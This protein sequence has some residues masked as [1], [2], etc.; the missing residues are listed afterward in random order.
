MNLSQHKRVAALGALTLLLLSTG[1]SATSQEPPSQK[2]KV[3]SLN[4]DTKTVNIKALMHYFN[5]SLN[6]LK[7]YMTSLEAFQNPQNKDSIRNELIQLEKKISDSQPQEIAETTGFDLSYNLMARHL[8]DTIR[9]YDSKIYVQAWE[10]MNATTTFCISCH[11]RLPEKVNLQILKD[12]TVQ[13]EQRP[14]QSLQDA[15]FYYLSHRYAHALE[16]YDEKIKNYPGNNLSPDE[17]KKIY[18]RKI[19]FYAR[20]HRNP[21]DAIESL[22]QDLKNKKLPKEYQ[23]HI[24][25]W[26]AGFNYLKKESTKNL[27]QLSDQKLL[28]YAQNIIS[29]SA[30]GTQISI[31]DPQAIP[32]LLSS[33]LLYERLFKNKNSDLVP[34]MLYALSQAE[35][36]LSTLR[37][38]SLSDIY[39]AECVSKY[40]KAAVA[41]LCFQD[42]ELSMK[43]KYGA[44]IPDYINSSIDTLRKKLQ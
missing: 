2:K 1:P 7:P 39:L 6:N 40:P 27:Q 37:L 22:R 42:Y 32:L 30:N 38:Y 14:V 18:E 33:G 12:I 44:T 19:A 41:K 16:I 25:T 13:G 31:T 23:E 24:K 21:N 4:T 5:G 8:R 11:T 15:E 35:R 20:V 9:L 17:L 34:D 28:S 43:T 36:Q 29:K 10:K 26:I 3:N